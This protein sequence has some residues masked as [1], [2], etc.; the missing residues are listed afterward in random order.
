MPRTR[1]SGSLPGSVKVLGLA[2]AFDESPPRPDT[3][4]HD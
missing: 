2:F 3:S 4:R 1:S